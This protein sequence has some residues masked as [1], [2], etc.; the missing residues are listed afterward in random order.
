MKRNKLSLLCCLIGTLILLSLT[1]CSSDGGSENDKPEETLIP[2]SVKGAEI[3]VGETTVQTLLDQGL[4]I[5]WMDENYEK[6]PIDP[7]EQLDADSYYTG[8]GL[9][10]SDHVFAHISLATEETPVHM[11]EAVIARLEFHIATED[12]ETVLNQ[13]AFDGVPVTELTCEKAQEMYP[14]WSG[15][16]VMWLKYGLEYSYDLNFDMSTGRL[17][18]FTVER[19]YDVDWNGTGQT[20]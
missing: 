8:G 1:A 14:D 3:K 19:K 11:S 6:I 12:D 17:T 2:I 13:L 4:E 7:D 15:N 10:L 9:W 16:E 18:Q 20:N 5:T